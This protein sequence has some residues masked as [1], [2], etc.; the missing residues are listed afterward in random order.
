MPRPARS[1][2]SIMWARSAGRGCSGAAAW[3]G[4]FDRV[5]ADL[6]RRVEAESPAHLARRMHYPCRWDPFFRDVMIV[7]D[8]YR[9][10]ARHFDFHRRQLTLPPPLSETTQG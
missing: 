4:L 3:R 5:I 6:H 7:A 9:Y 1:T 8:L 2:W 10:P